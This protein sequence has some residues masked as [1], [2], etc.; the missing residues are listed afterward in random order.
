M[1][2]GN[3]HGT[4]CQDETDGDL[5]LSVH[6]QSVNNED[7]NNTERPIRNTA[8]CGVSVERV[9]NNG[10]WNALAL[11]APELLPEVGYRPALE[12]EN[13]KEVDTVSL[14]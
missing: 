8:Q 3:L 4:E 13:E 5:L 9:D 10:R 11:S 6:L 7:R 1:V 14:D 2:E 12:S